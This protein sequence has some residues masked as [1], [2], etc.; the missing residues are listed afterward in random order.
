MP[1]S[2]RKGKVR[3]QAR[4]GEEHALFRRTEFGFYLHVGP[5]VLCGSQHIA[6]SPR[7]SIWRERRRPKVLPPLIERPVDEPGGRPKGR[8]GPRLEI[9][10]R[11][12]MPVRQQNR[13]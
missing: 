6:R 8:N 5:L 7:R 3:F 1:G 10:V 2:P 9:V 4:R 13:L 12:T 11:F